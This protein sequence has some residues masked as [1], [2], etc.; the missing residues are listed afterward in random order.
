MTF[1]SGTAL[2]AIEG[3]RQSDLAN[4]RW[5][6]SLEGLPSADITEHSL[7]HFLVYRDAI[8][9]AGAIGLERFDDVALLRSL[10][11]A[12]GH[13][14]RGLGERLVCAAGELARE[15]GVRAIYLLTTTA[16]SYFEALGFR[17]MK[18]EHAPP[19]IEHCSEFQSLCPSS[20][21][22]MVKP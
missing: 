18:R 1:A 13:L 22:L 16:E 11:V 14:R 17:H 8:G 9:I 4:I 3:A 2:S 21:V 12:D 20:A 6:L 19:A 10:V 5:L 7:E 15:L